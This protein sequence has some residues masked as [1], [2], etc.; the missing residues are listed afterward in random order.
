M[1]TGVTHRYN[2]GLPVIENTDVRNQT[3]I[4]DRVQC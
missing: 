1:I 4:E 2:N 3:G